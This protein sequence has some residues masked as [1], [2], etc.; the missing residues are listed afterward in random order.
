MGKGRLQRGPGDFF[1]IRR[2]LPRVGVSRR[3]VGPSVRIFSS[4]VVSASLQMVRAAVGP[5]RALAV[6]CWMKDALSNSPR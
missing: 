6:C 1:L 3:R 2:G 4:G 5:Y